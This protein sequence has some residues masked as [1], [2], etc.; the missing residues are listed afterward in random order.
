MRTASGL[1]L[2]LGM[3][4][5]LVIPAL[6]AL[7]A[8]E[9]GAVN[10]VCTFLESRGESRS[11]ARLRQGFASGRFTFGDF[12]AGIN[13]ETSQSGQT[14]VFGR[15]LA[16]NMFL[17]SSKVPEFEQLVDFA[18]T[19]VHE[20]KHLDQ[21]PVAWTGQYWKGVFGGRNNCEWEGWKAGFQEYFN[22]IE[23]A[24]RNLATASEEDRAEAAERLN[25][26]CNAF[27]VYRNGY[28]AA[29]GDYEMRIERQD[30]SM[31]SLAEA[32]AEA[33]GSYR[34]TSDMLKSLRFTVSIR[35]SSIEVRPGETF[36]LQAR[37]R[38]AE[39]PRYLWFSNGRSLHEYGPTLR[40]A[41]DLPETLSVEVENARHEKVRATCKVSVKVDDLRAELQPSSIRA[42]PGQQ[43]SIHAV[44]EGGFPKYRYA[45]MVG[46]ATGPS[47]TDTLPITAKDPVTVSVLVTDR[48]GT[49][50]RARCEVTIDDSLALRLQP[51]AKQVPSGGQVSVKAFPTGGTPP[52]TWQWSRGQ[53][54]L[55]GEKGDS[56]RATVTSDETWTATVTDAAGKVTRA[57]AEVTVTEAQVDLSGTWDVDFRPTVGSY[58]VSEGRSRVWMHTRHTWVLR[59]EGS[60]VTGWVS[61][62]SRPT[63]RRFADH[64]AFD[65]GQNPI[66]GTVSGRTVRLEATM[67]EPD[68]S[69]PMVFE[70]ELGQDGQSFGGPDFEER[71]PLGHG[72]TGKPVP[73]KAVKR[74]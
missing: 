35:P 56:L 38:K 12:K 32:L 21:S 62:V 33:Q 59:Q 44:V 27:I 65:R 49:K 10:A 16:R 53:G 57:T 20:F 11:A 72:V 29:V 31:A 14:I 45:W 61:G 30:G 39:E 42:T 6:A 54:P 71:W 13:A 34:L 25:S 24:Q 69:I 52:Y 28:L 19:A 36:S 47:T 5:M 51:T 26:T 2:L 41:A 73:W 18:V 58:R 64:F 8:E 15:D 22:L 70:G 7:N 17:G 1:I 74:P 60:S 66:R 23:E 55:P 4:V 50:V 46:H 9:Q 37:A 43:I 48:A 63:H 68:S 3:A 67:K 40:R